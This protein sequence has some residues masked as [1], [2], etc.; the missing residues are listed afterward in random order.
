VTDRKVTVNEADCTCGRINIGMKVT[1][2]RNWSPDCPK[3]GTSVR[4]VTASEAD[5]RVVVDVL[6]DHLGARN[7]DGWVLCCHEPGDEPL[8]FDRPKDHRLHVAREILA[9]LNERGWRHD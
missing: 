4:N 6:T 5:L 7:P 1:E 2:H 8:I 3:H 9:A